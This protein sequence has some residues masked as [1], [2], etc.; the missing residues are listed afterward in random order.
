M[1]AVSPAANSA[2][3]KGASPAAAPSRTSTARLST[4]AGSSAAPNR[5]T[6]ANAPRTASGS[7]RRTAPVRT[8][9]SIKSPSLLRAGLCMHGG[10]GE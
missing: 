6:A 8:D 2:M 7:G 9:L 3:A 5:P 4:H 1:P 10:G